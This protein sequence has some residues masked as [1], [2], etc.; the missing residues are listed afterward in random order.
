MID[1]E[2]AIDKITMGFK[3]LSKMT[4]K[5]KNSSCHETGHTLIAELLPCATR[6]IRFLLFRGIGSLGQ[7]MMLPEEKY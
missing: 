2:K 5:K 3:Q 6:S 4:E 1:L 7:T